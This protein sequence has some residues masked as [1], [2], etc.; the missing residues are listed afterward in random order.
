MK[1][2][3][4]RNLT[5]LALVVALIGLFVFMFQTRDVAKSIQS[6]D[7]VM[8]LKR[9][10][11]SESVDIAMAMK[12]VTHAPPKMLNPPSDMPTLLLYPPSDEDLRLLSGE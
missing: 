11:P 9:F 7:S 4:I 3:Q 10:T 6:R 2:V 12:M 8:D 5:I 1:R